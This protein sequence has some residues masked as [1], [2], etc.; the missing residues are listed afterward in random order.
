MLDQLARS[1]AKSVLIFSHGQFIRATAWFIQHGD[2]AGSP[3]LMKRFRE[4]D[5]GEPLLNCAGYEIVL[6]G[7]QWTVEF[8]LSQNGVV[9][10]IDHFCTD[11]STGPAPLAP[12]TREVRDFIARSKP[13]RG[14]PE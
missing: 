1:D 14:T 10:F 11:Q 8:Q 4:F 6:K 2:E 12:M 3:D 13:N 9:K 7:G 5:V